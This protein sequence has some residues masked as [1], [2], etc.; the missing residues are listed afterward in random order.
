MKNIKL[1]FLIFTLFNFGVIYAHKDRVE[2]PQRFVFIMRSKEVVRF[3][4]T[5]SKLEGF[6]EEIVSGKKEI[7]EVQLYYKT[8]EIVTVQYDGKNWKLFK[9]TFKGKSLYVPQDKLKKIPEIHFSTLYL[10]WSGESNA[11][12]S[13]YLCLRFDIGTKRSFDILPNLELHF[14][15]HKFTKS[16]VWTQTNEN[17]RHGK[18]I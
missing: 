8:G 3:E 11:F 4:S 6:C 10:F 1:F 17:S 5:D 7:S 18:E 2:I 16:E 15:N 13:H 12:N 9:I 14:E